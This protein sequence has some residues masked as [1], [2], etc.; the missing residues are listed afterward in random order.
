MPFK[1]VEYVEYLNTLLQCGHHVVC[2]WNNLH[3]T[4]T[5]HCDWCGT[6]QPWIRFTFGDR[7]YNVR[8][9]KRA[10]NYS[11]IFGDR[12]LSMQLDGKGHAGRT[13]HTTDLRVDS[14]VGR[15]I[16]VQQPLELEF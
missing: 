13:G 11:R 4:K 3:H 10:C 7:G 1:N 9:T 2:T 8:C 12:F 16:E 15:S 6:V 5:V 14:W